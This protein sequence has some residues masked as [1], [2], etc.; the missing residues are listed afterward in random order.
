MRGFFA[1]L[2]MTTLKDGM[3]TLKAQNDNFEGRNDNFEDGK[4]RI[5]DE[6]LGRTMRGRRD[7]GCAAA[8]GGL[9]G[10]DGSIG[11][12]GWRGGWRGGCPGGSAGDDTREDGFWEDLSIGARM[13]RG[14]GIPDRETR[15]ACGVQERAR[16]GGH[17]GGWVWVAEPAPVQGLYLLGGDRAAGCSQGRLGQPGAVLARRHARCDAGRSFHVQR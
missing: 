13:G 16:Q 7:G 15:R 3:T 14:R 11:R 5:Q 9:L 17:V 2:R 10:V 4:W 8:G 1:P 6:R 12:G